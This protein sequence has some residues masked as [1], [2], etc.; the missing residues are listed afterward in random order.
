[1]KKRKELDALVS[2]GKI[3]SSKRINCGKKASGSCSAHELLRHD[4]DSSD[5]E[6][7]SI[8]QPRRKGRKKHGSRLCITSVCLSLCQFILVTTSCLVSGALIWLHIGLREDID[9]LRTHLQKV[10]AGNRNTP[11]ALHVIHSSLKQLD[12]N[13]TLLY[14]DARKSIAD[15]ENIT[16]EVKLLKETA[17]SLKASIASAPAIQQLPKDMHSLSESVANFGSKLNALESNVKELKDQQSNLQST[18]QNL[19]GELDSVKI[20]VQD[21]TNS[22]DYQA[23]S[24]VN[25][26]VKDSKLQN[27]IQ[28]ANQHVE[29]LQGQ[30]TDVVKS[31][32]KINTTFRNQLNIYSELPAK[33]ETVKEAIVWLNNATLT[34]SSR[35]SALETFIHSNLTLRLD[36][37]EPDRPHSFQMPAAADIGDYV[38]KTI[39]EAIL[40]MINKGIF[41]SGIQNTNN[42]A[43]QSLDQTHDVL[44]LLASLLQK[45]DQLPTTYILTNKNSSEIVESMLHQAF[46]EIIGSRDIKIENLDQE[47]KN[48]SL[49]IPSCHGT[50]VATDNGHLDDT[51]TPVFLKSTLKTGNSHNDNPQSQLADALG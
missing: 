21:I 50:E 41:H 44:V 3:G 14:T 38:N 5:I 15:I 28:E 36:Q 13:V 1:M 30:L 20:S 35:I 9:L 16:S 46:E 37:L 47:L 33:V 29:T 48:L 25:T 43:M 22:T 17:N 10:E 45:F 40:Q 27:A 32:E 49:C 23:K 42:N 19:S 6:D 2:N 39:S 24:S 4:T 51:T 26:S 34:H 12:S 31:V 11:E 18:C 7:F 8:L